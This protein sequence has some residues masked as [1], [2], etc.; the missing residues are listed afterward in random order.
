M[1]EDELCFAPVTVDKQL[2]LPFNLKI[3]NNPKIR[4]S[5]YS[6]ISFGGIIICDFVFARM[7][8]MRYLL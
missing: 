8:S 1:P 3:P 2:I 7:R 4:A 5:L 6:I